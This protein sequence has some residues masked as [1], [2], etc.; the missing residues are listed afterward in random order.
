MLTPNKYLTLVESYI[1]I[2]GLILECLG[3]QSLTVDKLW[4]KFSKRNINR[5]NIKFPDYQKFIFSLDFMY[6]ADMISYNCDGE[7]YNENL[8]NDN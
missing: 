5:I 3:K 6:M 7:V 1:G 8:R 2:S 4:E